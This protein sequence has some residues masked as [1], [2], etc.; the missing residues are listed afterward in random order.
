M[1]EA[2]IVQITV[3]YVNGEIQKYEFERQAS[4]QASL[5]SRIQKTLSVNELMLEVED[6]LV[7]IPLPNI[8]RIEISP[9]PLKFPDSVIRG[10]R[11]VES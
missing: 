2:R 11:L 4:D 5:A 9:A 10:V 1:N 8:Q 6:K 3:Y 7:V